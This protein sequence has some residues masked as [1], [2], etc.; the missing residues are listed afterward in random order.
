MAQKKRAKPNTHRVV[1]F[2][3]KVKPKPAWMRITRIIGMTIVVTALILAMIGM[4][5]KYYHAVTKH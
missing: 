1:Y 2:N 5:M 4:A 3:R